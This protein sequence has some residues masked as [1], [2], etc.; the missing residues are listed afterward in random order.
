MDFESDK[1]VS[2]EISISSV[3]ADEEPVYI[4]EDSQGKFT[5]L[6]KT[7][8]TYLGLL[9][10]I[11]V[12]KVIRQ[13]GGKPGIPILIWGKLIKPNSSGHGIGISLLWPINPYTLENPKIKRV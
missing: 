6:V 5:V 8:L 1:F 4:A 10:K 12:Q 13:K 9:Q 11:K 7:K 2:V 3:Y